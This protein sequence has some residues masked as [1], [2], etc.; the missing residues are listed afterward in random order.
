MLFGK[1]GPRSSRERQRAGEGFRPGAEF[2]ESR[3]LLALLQLGAGTPANLAGQTTTPPN[4]PQTIA[5]QLP[6][7]AD[8]F[9]NT[10]T[11][12][13]TQ[14]N[15]TTDPGLGVLETGT[16]QAQG[17]GY[18]VAALADMNA[19]GS[20]DYLIGA[21]TVTRTGSV[22]TPSTGINNQAFLLF[23]NRSV[24][25]PVNQSWLSST[26]EQRVGVINGLG[27]TV[28]QFNPFTNRGQ[29]FDYK[30][31]GI[32]FITSQSTTS[33]LG[34]FVAAA[35]PNAFVIGA[36]NYA[37]GGRLY[38]V[39]ASS[40]FNSLTTK[41]VDLD[42]PQNYPG[43]TITTFIDSTNAASG[44]GNSFAFIPNLFG[45]GVADVAIGEP[46]AN[47]LGR[48]TNGGVFIYQ[49]PTLPTV[50][51]ARNT[52]DIASGTTT[53]AAFVIAGAAS[54]NQAGSSIATAGNAN[55]ATGNVNDILI[56]APAANSN[57]GIAY[58]LYGGTSLTQ[59]ATNKVVDLSR[60]NIN[61]AT[62]PPGSI[63]PP[64]GAV[65]LGSGTD[66]A[67][68]SVGTAGDFN[69]DGISDFMIGSPGANGGA[70]RVN[71]IYGNATTPIT[72][73]L[74]NFNSFQLSSLPTNLG[75]SSVAFTGASFGDRL[76]YS[77]SAVGSIGTGSSPILIG[78][79]GTNS[80]QGTVFELLGTAGK[81]FTT[82]TTLSNSSTGV[83][84]IYTLAF[85]TTFNSGDAIGFGSSV[86]SYFFQSGGDFV[87]GAPGYTGTL[88]TTTTTPPIPLVGAAAVVLQTLQPSG[89]L[90]QLGGT[91]GGGGGGGGGST[92]G[93]FVTS[94]IPPGVFKPPTFIPP[95]GTSFVPKISDLSALNYAPL[96]LNVAL[97]QYLP[98]NGFRQRLYLWEHP[99]SK[100]YP[101][102]GGRTMNNSGRT[103]KP[104]GVWT[105]GSR[106]FTR[107][108]FHA[109][110]SIA[111]THS[112][113]HGHTPGRVVPEQLVRERFTSKGNHLK[114]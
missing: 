68:F 11:G 92:V 105:L 46:G 40:G 110:N 18:R 3:T 73:S 65:L 85:P 26:P 64:V 8:T 9:Y 90:P 74:N 50:A 93:G 21:P 17:V 97:N 20:N 7:I 87:A 83:A 30:F 109:G 86:S 101:P 114:Q 33:Q 111:W 5:G 28:S 112:D 54:T 51:G 47:L 103:Y 32:T 75:F 10:T 79:P 55:G 25:V 2:L 37:G 66:Q 19:D 6:F 16:L 84:R 14:G 78:A 113:L 58:I 38:Y 13:Q 95:F 56:G 108:R 57:A 4:G 61:P 31:D 72:S 82:N 41:Q 48:T 15:Q 80:G 77:I 104:L 45:D 67:G 39:S 23:G 42:F 43:L 94:S 1:R 22:I 60:V 53:S 71:V 88:P 98:P 89:T 69:G 59:S 27:G 49:V 76:G 100:V 36:P 107:G 44:L 35:G 81:T 96:P 12:A 70:G 99:G 52:V 29:P 34:A 91:S 62:L 63:P 106:V 102:L 24:T